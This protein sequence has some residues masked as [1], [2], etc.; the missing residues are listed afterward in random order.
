MFRVTCATEKP[1]SRCRSIDFEMLIAVKIEL[2]LLEVG[3]H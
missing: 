3:F 2:L 1:T